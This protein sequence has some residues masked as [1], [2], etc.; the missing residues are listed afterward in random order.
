MGSNPTARANMKIGYQGISGA[1]SEIAAETFAKKEELKNTEFIGLVDFD[2]IFKMVENGELEYGAIPVENSLAGSIHKNFDLLGQHNL[3][4]VGEVYVHVNHQLLALP[5][6]KLSD[7]KEVY[8]HYQALAQC[9]HNIKNV[10]PNAKAVEHFDTA[11]SADFVMKEGDKSKASLASV[12]AGKVYGLKVLKKDFQ[13]DK[14]NY[15][16]FLII[17]KEYNDLTRPLLTKERRSVQYKT[18]IIFSGG[19][20]TGFLFKALGC[21]SLRDINLLKIESR[22]IPKSPWKIMFYLDFEGKYNDEKINNAI[23]NLKEYANEVKVLGSYIAD[24]I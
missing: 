1:Y 5:N 7:I 11:G 10:L 15:T 12:K 16:R 9:A 22:P 4:V 24:K 19:D 14:E 18:S 13:D 3:K 6:A 2:S 8:S 21:F 17:G 23:N 20:V